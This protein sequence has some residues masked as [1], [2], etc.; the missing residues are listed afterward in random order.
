MNKRTGI[1]FYLLLTLFV[2]IVMFPFFWVFLTSIKPVGEIF[3]SFNWFTKNPSIDS[4]VAAFTNRPLLRYIINSLIVSF[5][6]TLLSIAFA[7]FA[8]YALTRL[9]I[10]GKGLILGIVL[11]SSMFPQIAIL[12]PMFNFITDLG[13]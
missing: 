11:A 2:F 6:T 13:L 3:S 5:A 9:P 7:S 8:S 10:R 4:Y 12:S 1:G